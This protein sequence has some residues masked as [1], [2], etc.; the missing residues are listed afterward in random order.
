MMWKIDAAD[1]LSGLGVVLMTLAAFLIDW[2]AGLLVIGLWLLILGG[3]L[4]RARA[5]G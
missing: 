2:R 3:L 4:A 1:V 5:G